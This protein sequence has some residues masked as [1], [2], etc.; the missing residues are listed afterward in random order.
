MRTTTFPR[1]GKP[2]TNQVTTPSDD[3]RR[4]A[5][6]ADTEIVVTC[7][8]PTQPDGIRRSGHAW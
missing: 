4:N 2:V 1:S 6:H 7:G 3:D 5:T 8:N